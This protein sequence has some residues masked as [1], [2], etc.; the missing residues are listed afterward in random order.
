MADT[1]PLKPLKL[2]AET[3]LSRSQERRAI[4][5]DRAAR[6]LRAPVGALSSRV[7]DPA[8]ALDVVRVAAWILD[9]I[10]PWPDVEVTAGDRLACAATTKVATST[11][12]LDEI[13]ARAVRRPLHSP[14][15][16][17]AGRQG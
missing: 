17:W 6:T 15:I 1:K 4:A 7:G 14:I 3:R 11:S 10:D 5:L 2:K 13:L 12:S 9:G 16:T 8:D